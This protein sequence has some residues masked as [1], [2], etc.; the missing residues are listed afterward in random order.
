MKDEMIVWV[1]EKVSH[2]IETLPQRSIANEFLENL[3]NKSPDKFLKTK[4]Y[5]LY[6]EIN[7]KYYF[8]KKEIKYTEIDKNIL[9]KIVLNLKQKYK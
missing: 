4:N 8:D 7:C 1:T 6:L 5:L 9:R 2:M 3:R